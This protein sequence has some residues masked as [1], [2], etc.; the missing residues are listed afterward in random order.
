M[1]R[2]NSMN[3]WDDDGGNRGSYD[4]GGSPPEQQAWSRADESDAWGRQRAAW[5]R[6]VE[7]SQR[8]QAPWSPWTPDAAQQTERAEAYR[9]GQQ[10]ASR[11]SR[12]VSD[13]RPSYRG[14]GPKSF[15]R[16]DDQLRNDICQRLSDHDDVDATDID[17]HVESGEATLI[18]TVP[19]RPMKRLAEDC[20]DACIGISNVQNNLRVAPSKDTPHTSRA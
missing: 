2:P 12:P 10:Q 13:D 20:A 19:E 14:K 1:T 17:V 16:S 11:P 8:G 6:G 5:E 18:G 15:T 4:R 9:R 3:R 7:G